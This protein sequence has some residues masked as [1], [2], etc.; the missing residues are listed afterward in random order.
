MK[1]GSFI[2]GKN[3]GEVR[4]IASLTKIMTCLTALKLVKHFR[5]QVKNC[6]VKVSKVAASMIGTSARLKGGDVLTLWDLLHGMMLPSGNDAAYAI[7]EYFGKLIWEQ[8]EQSGQCESNPIPEDGKRRSKRRYYMRQFIRQ[9][10]KNASELSLKETLF[11]NSHGL[12]H[13]F[14][15]SSARDVGQLCCSALANEELLR[16]VNTK[17]YNCVITNSK[18]GDG[19]RAIR[20]ENTNKLLWKG[21][22]GI[23]TGITTAAGPCL[24]SAKEENGRVVIC[25]L[26]GCQTVDR[27][28]EES[29]KLLAYGSYKLDSPLESL[30]N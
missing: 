5:I 11:A 2:A 7:A 4:E 8:D 10:N 20:W 14:N 16:I 15:R 30:E 27:R 18:R 17:E 22:L 19:S 23:K 12:M 3:A 29:E 28:W 26:L 24:A 25:V 13:K 6:S 1:K 21:F 9:M